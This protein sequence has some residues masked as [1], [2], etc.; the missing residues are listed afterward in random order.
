MRQRKLPAN[1][2]IFSFSLPANL[3]AALYRAAD[4]SGSGLTAADYVR[5]LLARDL[6]VQMDSVDPTPKA[7]PNSQLVHSM[8]EQIKT[9]YPELNQT[10]TVR[11]VAVALD[12][13]VSTINQIVRKRTLAQNAEAT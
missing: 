10:E 12:T 3:A 4:Q 11:R 1:S 5:N 7:S 8:L 9:G 13:P 6:K 2:K